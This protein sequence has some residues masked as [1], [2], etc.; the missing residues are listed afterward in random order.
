[1]QRTIRAVEANLPGYPE[2]DKVLS[3]FR[4][5]EYITLMAVSLPELKAFLVATP[6]FGGLSDASLD[7]LISMLVER[8]FDVSFRR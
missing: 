1:M 7:L 2:G 4:E 5:Q 8:R 3:S 6:F